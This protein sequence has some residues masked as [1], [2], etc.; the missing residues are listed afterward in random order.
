MDITE[1][2]IK[3]IKLLI[4]VKFSVKTVDKLADKRSKKVFEERYTL[5]CQ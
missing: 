4:Y 3:L 1:L 2:K 5:E